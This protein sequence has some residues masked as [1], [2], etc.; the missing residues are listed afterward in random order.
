VNFVPVRSRKPG[1]RSCEFRC[2]PKR[3]T[4]IGANSN[5]LK[6]RR[7]VFRQPAANRSDDASHRR[8][9]MKV[10]LRMGSA[11]KKQVAELRKSEHGRASLADRLFRENRFY[12][13]ECSPRTFHLLSGNLVEL[14]KFPKPVLDKSELISNP[15]LR[16]LFHRNSQHGNWATSTWKSRIQNGKVNEING[17]FLISRYLGQQ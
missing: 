12:P 8:G 2:S 4:S 10:R 7:D 11:S 5:V 3:Q 13:G 6:H 17:R 14:I 1:A 9:G 15:E 16:E